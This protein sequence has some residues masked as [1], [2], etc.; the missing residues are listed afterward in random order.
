MER[1][2]LYFG[3]FLLF[4]IIVIISGFYS[5]INTPKT[6]N[7]GNISFQYTANFQ[8]TSQVPELF[9]NPIWWQNLDNLNSN[10]TQVAIIVDKNPKNGS[11]IKTLGTIFE[12][13]FR[14]TGDDFVYSSEFTNPNGVD[15][16]EIVHKAH[17]LNQ[18]YLYYDAYF[19]QGD[20]IYF[21]QVIGYGETEPAAQKVADM[22]FNSTKVLK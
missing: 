14:D 18:S 21:I 4:L 8:N 15:I 19:F 10:T 12:K 13:Y 20:N 7:N 6:Y 3:I 1:K 11:D 9:N 16:W 17:D 2:T 22:V 5:Y